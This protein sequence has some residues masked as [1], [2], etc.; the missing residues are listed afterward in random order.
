MTD[1]QNIDKAIEHYKN[2]LEVFTPDT[3]PYR[4]RESAY[5]LGKIYYE[6]GN[7]EQA[8]E[9]FET[10][11]KSVENI[12][13]WLESAE[14]KKDLA[15]ENAD[16]YAH[17]VYVCLESGDTDSAFKYTVA[18]KGRSFVDWLSSKQFDLSSAIESGQI[19]RKDL[20]PIYELYR[21]IDGL[22]LPLIGEGKNTRGI[23]GIDK[24]LSLEKH[25]EFQTLRRKVETL[26]IELSSKYPLL[27]AT[28]STPLL[29]LKQVFQ[30][31]K[32]LGNTILVEYFRHKEGWMAFVIQSNKLKCVDLSVTDNFLM[33]AEKWVHLIHGNRTSKF[34]PVSSKIFD[35]W[36]KVLIEPLGLPD[37]E[38]QRVILAPYGY[39]HR[40]P[41]NISC[42]AGKFLY[43]KCTLAFIPS[44]ASLWVVLQQYKK[45]K[46]LQGQQTPTSKLLTIAYPGNDIKRKTY[47]TSV[48]IEAITI[49][50]YWKRNILVKYLSEKGISIDSNHHDLSVENIFLYLYLN[51]QGVDVNSDMIRSTV[52][53]IIKYIEQNNY[54]LV[55]PNALDFDEII[56]G[57]RQGNETFDLRVNEMAIFRT[58]F[59][60]VKNNGFLLGDKATP[61]IKDFVNFL[62]EN[63]VLVGFKAKVRRLIEQARGINSENKTP[64]D[65]LSNILGP[66]LFHAAT[67][68]IFYEEMPDQSAVL[69]SGG[70]LT[71]QR[72]ITELYLK[73]TR[74][75]TLGA[76]LTA[77]RSLSPAEEHVG[78]QQALLIAGAISTIGSLWE[79]DDRSTHV[80]FKK[81]YALYNA[82]NSHAE[83]LKYAAKFVSNQKKGWNHPYF[84][85]AFQVNGLAFINY[86]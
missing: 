52:K 78:L 85:A 72:I 83:S 17:L 49:F 13:G 26:W 23:K 62:E 40:I 57:L 55:G 34:A 66:E 24:K 80:F 16:L 68:G 4:C 77:M 19:D 65:L 79:V 42:D 30:L 2:A 36:H 50:L 5:R 11:H 74:L 75:A 84:W 69:L 51:E 73:G 7:Y 67:H 22:I 1:K 28:Q 61:A 86:S 41:L 32:E 54:S 29:T 56:K 58:I 60:D 53:K 33:K 47:L 64:S 63:Q 44:L 46:K 8:K 31:A 48:D 6:Q 20:E 14:S 43:E 10:A 38:N 45:D 18:G 15:E 25:A 71:V 39:L 82:G 9:Y 76:C 3:F 59:Q 12:R 37:D 70:F 35:K 21:Q 81:F 27:T